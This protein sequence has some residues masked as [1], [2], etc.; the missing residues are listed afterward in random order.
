[1]KARIAALAVA[2]AI[3]APFAAAEESKP[4]PWL[5]AQYDRKMPQCKIDE[6]N[7]P[8]G[9]TTCREGY[10]HVCTGRGIWER[11]GKPC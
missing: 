5:V 11:T 8:V 7:V 6:R 4:A 2:L 1:M 10:T 9:S 3:G